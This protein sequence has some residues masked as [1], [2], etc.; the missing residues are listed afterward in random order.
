MLG[1]YVLD[2]AKW[3]PL[4]D[5][6]DAID[7]RLQSDVD[8]DP[9]GQNLFSATEVEAQFASGRVERCVQQLAVDR[10][11]ELP[12]NSIVLYRI[13]AGTASAVPALS[14]HLLSDAADNEFS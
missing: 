9:A 3:Q 1:E 14:T 4:T 8:V 2:I 6:E 12:H 13:E 11:V 10:C 7:T 5:I